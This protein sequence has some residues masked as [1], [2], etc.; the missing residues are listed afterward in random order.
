MDI[1]PK[2]ARE[3]LT[4]MNHAVSM[5]TQKSFIAMTAWSDDVMHAAESLNNEVIL[6]RRDLAT[7]FAGRAGK[8]GP[9]G[10]MDYRSV[11]EEFP[12]ICIDSTKASFFDDA[13]SL[14][15]DT[16]E[17]LVHVVDVGEYMRRY[18]ILQKI[19]QERLA[20]AFLPTGPVHMLP[21]IALEGI[22]LSSESPNEV[23]T[24]GLSIDDVT[25]KLIGFRVFPSVIGPVVPISQEVADTIIDSMRRSE[26]EGLVA[27]T[28]VGYSKAFMNNLYRAS[29]LVD[30]LIESEPWVDETFLA[31]KSVDF[32]LDKR[33]GAYRQLG[34]SKT[35]SNR[36]V[37]A[38]LSAYS[39]ASCEF[40]IAKNVSVPIAWENR[41][42]IDSSRISRFGTRPLRSWIAQ[43]QQ[44]QLR[45]ALK[46]EL[47]LTRKEC[48]I[49]VTYHSVNRKQLSAFEKRGREIM[50]YESLESHCLSM[51]ASGQRNITLF[52]CL[53]S[54]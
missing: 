5:P 25:G 34:P 23:I 31:G 6:R 10:R 53:Y 51:A 27:M 40:C 12:P 11:S 1:D 24:V 46:L 54:I 38:L 39:N 35:P 43:L 45:S 17:V 4:R 47:P 21:P 30:K 28:R 44:K 33:T 26:E 7:S 37:N 3:L 2:G 29:K 16:G 42:K 15:P 14:S 20:S 48:A 18:P 52:M 8:R 22:K 50:S 19:A 41:D 49:A 9:S 36:M 13:F 32:S